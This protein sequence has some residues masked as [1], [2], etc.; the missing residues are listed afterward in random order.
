MYIIA[1]VNSLAT[2]V[3]LISLIC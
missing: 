3:L 1:W 2:F